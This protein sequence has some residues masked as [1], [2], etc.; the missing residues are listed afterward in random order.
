[1]SVETNLDLIGTLN[2]A[3]PSYFWARTP[4]GS[5]RH[6]AYGAADIMGGCTGSRL[7]ERD[8]R[9]SADFH[10]PAGPAFSSFSSN[11]PVRLTRGW[12]A[13]AYLL[14]APLVLLGA[15]AAQAQTAS[16]LVSNTGQSDGGIDLDPNTSGIIQRT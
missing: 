2:G 3:E 12:R 5:L 1:M 6:L 14:T 16:K 11:F 7:Q 8:A 15:G 9:L 10:R 4:G 13:A